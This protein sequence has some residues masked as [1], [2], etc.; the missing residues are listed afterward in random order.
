MKRF[1]LNHAMFSDA[2]YLLYEDDN[3]KAET[4]KFPDGIEALKV[5][6]SRGYLTLLP[7]YGLIVWDAVF[8]GIKL[9]EKDGFKQ[10]H[11][12]N[13]IAD[14]YGAFEFTSGLLANGNPGPEDHHVQHGE[15]ATARMDHAYL[16]VG[17]DDS[18]TVQS[19][20]EYIKGFG[21][22]YIEK[23]S[24]TLH[25]DS[26]LFDIRQHVKNLSGYAPM[27]LQ[28]MCHLCYAYVDNAV[29]TSNIPDEAF[30]LRTSVPAHVH[31]TPEWTKFTD[32]LEKSGKMIDKL[33]DASHYDPEIVFFSKD[34]RKYTDKAEFRMDL[35]NGH[36][37]LTTFDTENLPIVTRWIL[38]NADQQ[39]AAYCL[40]GT[41]TPEGQTA[42]KKAGT[43]IMLQ[44]GEE[45]DFHVVTGLEK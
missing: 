20:Y 32:E 12:G 18:I 37:F 22:H 5:S 4:Y 39:V 45:K 3:F 34:L 19:D 27:T 26:G 7:F 29:M 31:P 28:Y 41:C 44:P 2:K 16:E 43:L 1:N 10:P 23:P 13:Q 38:F 9:K 8:D 35:G 30:Q 21:D 6:N 17:D 40:P 11:W 15:A 14:T 42:A 36:S 24:V 25:Q 33:D